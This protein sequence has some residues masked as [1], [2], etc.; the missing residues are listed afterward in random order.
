MSTD[1]PRRTQAERTEATRAALIDAARALFTERGY[2]AVATEEIV[3]RAGV[4]RGALYHHFADKE[5]L[6]REVVEVLEAE[7]TEQIARAALEAADPWEALRVGTRIFLDT[8]TEPETER[9][10]LLD[11]PSVLGWERLREIASRHG[12]GLLEAALQNAMDAGLITEQPVRPL[13]H[14]L[15]GGLTEAALLIGRA[16]DPKHA[17]RDVEAMLQRMLDSIRG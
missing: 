7:L 4:T 16:E 12:L 3:K 13:A 6:F 2:A 17:R 10:V 15:F 5:D 9:I 11:A 8:C 14:F 1:S